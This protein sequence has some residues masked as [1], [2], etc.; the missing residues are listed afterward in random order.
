VR[1]AREAPAD[2]AVMAHQHGLVE[3][4]QVADG[5]DAPL[6]EARL[7]RRAD[8]P[9]QA[10]RLR[11]QE[12]H[13]FG[14]ADHREAARLVEVGRDLGEELVVAEAD[15]DRDAE[16]LLDAA[17]QPAQRDGGAGV[18]R[19]LGPGQV[20][21]GLVDRDRLDQRRRLAHQLADL[22]A[23]RAVL[24]HVGRDDGGLWTQPQ[25]LEHRH[26]GVQAVRARD[27]AARRDHP[28]L[29]AADHHRLV[30]QLGAVALLDRGV[31]GVAVDVGDPEVVQLDMVN[32][33]RRAAGGAP[34]QPVGRAAAVTVAAQAGNL[35]L[36]AVLSLPTKLLSA[37]FLL[38]YLVPSLAR[39]TCGHYRPGA[40][41]IGV[42]P[43][44]GL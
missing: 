36:H 14:A 29:A 7:E 21:K 26:R 39:G 13:R 2:D 23:D 31:E 18:V 20:E 12:R 4:L 5:R 19:A 38:Y 3:P 15:R 22:P 28:A 17:S 40:G 16:L 42:A 30:D 33:P 1:E 27:V 10:D 8:A 35:L 43:R 37:L 6:G 32:A 9:D 25:G 34:A 24:G 11:R 41:A 44:Q